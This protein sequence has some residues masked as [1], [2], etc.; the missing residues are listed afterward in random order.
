MSNKFSFA[1]GAACVTVA[2]LAGCGGGGGG[3]GGGGFPI[4]LPPVAGGSSVTVS[5]TATYESVPNLNGPLVYASTSVKPVRGAVVDVLDAAS[6]ATLA[7]TSTD[8]AGA[9]SINVPANTTII[10]RV[11]AQLTRT[12]VLPSW[13]VSV[14]DNTSQPEPNKLYSMD[15]P[16]FGTG[17]TALTR[18]LR[19][20]TGWNGSG[21][22]PGPGQ[23]VAAPF[24]VLD[25]VYTS[26][27]KVL[28]A[29]PGT[30]FP[31][32]RVFWSPNNRPAAGSI[33]AGEIGSTFFIN[34]STGREIYVLGQENVD[35]D[36]FDSP[37]IAHE[38]GHYYQSAFSRDDSPGG[39]HTL[40]ERVDR[41]LAFS[42][43]WGNG[44]SGIALGRNNY[45][46]S[47]GP[48]QARG[49]NVNLSAGPATNPG[50]YREGSIQS[51][52]WNLN[53]Q[54]GFKPIND[55]MT[56]ILFRGGA[57]VSSIH[58]FTAA[59]N[60]T[61]PG[62]AS[63]LANLLSGQNISTTA[64][65]PYGDTETNGG[66]L[67]AVPN[68]VQPMYRTAT[69]GGAPTQACVSNLDGDDNKLG[70]F[71]YL[72]F[73]APA[74]RDYQFTVNGGPVGTNP[75]FDIFRGGLVARSSNKV[76]LGAGDYVLAVS[77]IN[78]FG[79]STCFN[80]TIQ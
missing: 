14:R 1:F 39:P 21:Y 55:A 63:V 59:F 70:S 80:V 24:A 5:G 9:Y 47:L 35:T 53:Q 2:L 40:A 74:N 25:T 56:S 79:S 71:A 20:V 42:E 13:D 6:S 69:V 45:V 36:E 3:G 32:L 37:V 65:D 30:A 28:S 7:T 60:A 44:W 46:D 22:T 51:I 78:N 50:W 23:R 27:Q 8:D 15:S 72:R 61:T 75:D 68:V 10:V 48:R 4:V 16:A 11:K 38:W 58:P 41:R 33:A 62:S 12:G 34:R 77:D 76:S 29:A 57:P 64:N 43:G 26:M 52:F 73:T 17:A 67:P 49:G 18:D 54:V 19:A 66:G 31:A